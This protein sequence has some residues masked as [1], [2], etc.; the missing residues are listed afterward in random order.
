MKKLFLCTI[1]ASIFLTSNLQAFSLKSNC[2]LKTIIGKEVFYINLKQVVSISHTTNGDK[3][4]N[5]PH[6]HDDN[7]HIVLHIN[8]GNQYRLHI[9]DT[10]EIESILLKYESCLL[11]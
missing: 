2:I 5:V 8:K 7:K 3:H 6:K 9:K 4:L 11:K 10:N 1:F